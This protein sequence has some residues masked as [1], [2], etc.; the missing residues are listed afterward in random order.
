MY[1]RKTSG[2]SQHLDFMTLDLL[3]LEAS[4]ILGFAMHFGF[5]PLAKNRV[6]W[7]LCIASGF[8][9]L[10]IMV[11]M[12]SYHNVIRRDIFQELRMLATQTIYLTVGI[13]VFIFMMH[14]DHLDIFN[15]LMPSIPF[16]ALMCFNMRVLWREH[17]R[18]R[19][20]MK[21]NTSMLILAETDRL[22]AATASWAWRCWT[23][24]P[25]FPGRKK[26]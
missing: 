10:M 1:R 15:I 6:F 25:T 5:Q 8:I 24:I 23:N 21:N 11:L 16:Y 13:V 19:L 26:A 12:D 4:M 3:C 22:T 20:H 2:W 7:S 14:V 17:L 9:D 18:H